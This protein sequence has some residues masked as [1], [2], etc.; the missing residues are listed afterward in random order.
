MYKKIC[1]FFVFIIVSFVNA[2]QKNFDAVHFTLKPTLTPDANDVIFSF[3]GDL[4]KVS[5]SGGDAFRLTAMDGSETNP[6]VSPDGK[7]L[8][9][10]SNQ[11]G[12]YDVYVM[13]LKG[14]EITQLTFHQSGDMVSSWNWDSKTINFTSGRYNSVTNYTVN[15]NGGTPK[16]T[17]NHYFNTIHNVVEHPKTNDIYFNESWESSRFAHRKRYKGDYNPDIKSYNLKSK[18]YTKHT[19]YRGKD[20]GTTIDKSGTI[21][22]KS[23][24]HNGEYNLYT[25]QNGEKK[26]LTSFSTSIMW[27]KVSANGEKVVFRKEYQ[28]FVYDVAK[29]S[30]KKLNFN[31]NRN[32]TI[33]KEQSYD[34]KGNITFFDISSDGKKMAFISRGKLFISDVKGKFVKEIQTNPLEAVKEVKWLSDNNSVVFSRSDKGYYNWFV[35]KADGTSTTNQLTKNK[36]NNR[37]ITLNID[38]TKGVYL[39]GRNEIYTI[40]LKTYKSE[41]IVKDELW[42]IYNADPYFSPDG[43]YILYTAYRDFEADIFVHN[44]T[45]KQTK[46][47]TNTKVSESEPA[48]SSDGK[49]IYFSSERTVPR[50]PSGGNG[51][52]KVYQMALDKYEK[53]F[54]IDKVN[55]LFKEEEKKDKK[56]KEDKEDKEDEKEKVKEKVIVTINEKGLMDRL[57]AISPR[58]GNQ[59]NITVINDGNKTHILYIS[60]HDQGKSKLWKTTLEPFEDNKTVK[61]N[62]TPMFGYQ[63]IT[64]DKKHYILSKGIINT[65]NLGTNKL[66]PIAIDYS[67]NKSLSDEFNQMYYEAWAGMEENF[68]DEN[69]HGENWQKLR[70]DYAAYL[71]YVSSRGNLRLIFNDMLGELNTSHFGFRSNGKEEQTYYGTQTL[72]T[73][74]V[75]NNNNPFVIERIVS[76]GPTDV[77]GKDLRK[78]DKL[79]AVNGNS[80][81]TKSNREHYFTNPKFKSEMSLTFSRDGKEFSVNV[82]LANF[83]AV[84][85]LVYDEWQDQNQAYVDKKTNNKVAYVHM[86]NMSGSEL[87]KFYHDL[88]SEEAYKDGLILDLRYNTGGNVHDAVLNFLRQKKYLN[89]KYREGKLTSQSNFSYGDKPIVLLINEQS[90]SDAEM[91]AAGFKELGMGTIVGTET[92][93]WIVF[94]TSNSLVDGSSYR[95]PTWGCYTLDGKNLETHGVTPD[96]Y[97][98][99]NF[100]ER[101]ENE[102]PQLDKAIEIILKKLEKR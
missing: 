26:R 99:E 76:E 59:R 102:N 57:T 67:F 98:G 92:Y 79:V 68:Y 15:I 64:V 40:D 9:F 5:S 50:F 43:N 60:N 88:V 19:S 84:K 97:V 81:D 16:R 39:R 31:I 72:E 4:W 24:Q 14:G 52:S 47:L 12:N 51:K 94:T 46:N 90:L 80:V 73:G 78:G 66:K 36:S 25:F 55:E 58:F 62:D 23:D 35:T 65:V 89:W 49:Y 61:L 101:L 37:Q 83:W 10:S 28:L 21:Y 13:P 44:L 11:F 8:A 95:L 77:K 22:F 70:D 45:T 30:T 32:S 17:F 48:W 53:P 71:P 100:K 33:N 2:Q 86:K 34:V 82:H 18:K 96:V 7:W 63:F 74:I 93:R 3:E 38:K 42:G 27:P 85:D 91:T 75:F 87:T 6:S 69:F 29:N 56:D 54:K 1:I 41:L 20:F